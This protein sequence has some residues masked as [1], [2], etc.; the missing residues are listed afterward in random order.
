M[1]HELIDAEFADNTGLYL[2]GSLDNLQKAEKE[3]NTFCQASRTRINGNKT[4]GFWVHC[5]DPPTWSPNRCF[6]WI[7]KVT[8][9]R[10]LGC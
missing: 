9:I 5:D 4:M 8:T 3:I 6:K 7:P 10:Y 1:L 2:Q